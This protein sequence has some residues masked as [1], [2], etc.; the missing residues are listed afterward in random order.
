MAR[1][2]SNTNVKGTIKA[3]PVAFIFAEHAQQYGAIGKHA[4]IE[5]VNSTNNAG[6]QWVSIRDAFVE[7]QDAGFARETHDAIFAAG[8]AV[9][10]KKAP[11]YRT[12]KSILNSA[13]EYKLTVTKDM[14]MSAL[15]KAIK[16]AKEDKAA[17]DPTAAAAKAQQLIEMFTKMAQG[18]L[19]AGIEKATLAKVLK[20]IE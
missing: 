8:D 2:K 5:A 20:S 14:G 1:S 7:G 17:N 3:Q 9:K 18:C 11:W 10:G 12:Y 13:I 4:A 19:N 15:Q 16:G 6:S